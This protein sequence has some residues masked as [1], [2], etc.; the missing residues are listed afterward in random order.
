MQKSLKND[1]T[2]LAELG[3]FT[4]KFANW[5]YFSSMFENMKMHIETMGENQLLISEII[6]DNKIKC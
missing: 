1:Q 4:V 5:K 2:V 3:Q 6:S